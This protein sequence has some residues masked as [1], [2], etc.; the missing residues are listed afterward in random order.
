MRFMPGEELYQVADLSSVWVVADVFEQ[1][2][3]LV[4]P[5]RRPRCASTPIRTRLRRQGQLR[6]SDAQCRHADG[7]G[8]RRTRQSGPAA[9]AGDVRQVELPVAAKGSVVTVPVSA[10]IDSGTRQIVLVQKGEG[11]F[12]PREVKLGARSDAMSRSSKASR[13]ASR[14]SS[15]PTS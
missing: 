10:V 11:R 6:L 15:P 12:E 2:I 9:E 8:A 14:W 5:G 7:S 4:K 3:G 1:D 13:T